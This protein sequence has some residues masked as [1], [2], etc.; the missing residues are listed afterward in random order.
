[1]AILSKYLKGTAS[2]EEQNF[3]HAYYNLFMADVDVML[4]L[5]EDEK[6]K[7]KLNIKTNIDTRLKDAQPAPQKKSG[8]LWL[9]KL[10]WAGF[11]IAAVL[12]LVLGVGFWFYNTHH[13]EKKTS[14]DEWTAADIPPGHNG[15][16]LTLANGKVIRLSDEK[17]GV[18]IGEEKLAYDD[19]S[20]VAERHPELN[21]GNPASKTAILV[22]AETAKGQTYQFTLPD[23]TRV[24]LNADSKIAFPSKFTGSE[25]NV[26]L[27]GEGYF[28]V[29]KD[30]KRPFIVKSA[31][32][33]VK[34]LGTHFNIN[35]YKDGG[36]IKTTLLEGSVQLGLTGSAQLVVLE[37]GQQAI[38]GVNSRI[39]VTQ[40]DTEMAVAWKNGDFVFRQEPLEN[41]MRC[42]ARWYNI[43][44]VYKP[45][46][47]ITE[48][49]GGRISRKRDLAEVL[50]N[51]EV[52][53]K[54]K[55]RIEGRKVYV[56]N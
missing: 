47:D 16:T 26:Q 48:S 27:S 46:T 21:S 10:S 14:A 28:E 4:L 32:Q 52:P 1:M 53:G 7:L 13:Y 9:N 2:R 33:A 42:I 11:A 15:A 20:T 35:A 12:L 54:L 45:G 17:N 44:V 23:G 22:T 41:M 37:P 3:L 36:N 31:G 25:R 29:V 38:V 19:G 39:R 43:D 18:V 56:S 51:M 55:F 34:V 6:E 24:W 49:F 30:K 40:A 50:E 5:K 8:K